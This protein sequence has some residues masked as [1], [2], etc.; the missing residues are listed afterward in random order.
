MTDRPS[1]VITGGGTGIGFAVA[2]RLLSA[3]LDV[4]IAGRRESVLESAATE[5]G[6][7][8]GAGRVR[9]C[10]VDIGSDTGPVQ[11]ISAHVE[12]YG[13][14]AALVTAAAIYDAVGFTEITREAWDRTMRI[15]V[16]GA[17][18]C[19]VEA[20]RHMVANGHGRIVFIGSTN[21]YHA[22]RGSTLYS[23][24]KTALMSVAKSIAVDLAGT[25]VVGN[26]VAPGWT[27]TPMAAKDIDRLGSDGMKH[28][29]PQGRAAR[30]EEIAE[31][32]WYLTAD[33]PDHLSGQTIFVDGGQTA[34]AP[35]P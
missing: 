8:A 24:S 1:A 7:E 20:T 12:S 16:R 5:L 14:I 30:P 33:A 11:L 22:E 25:G 10:A 17:V 34:M 2:R 32:V 23:A 6:R 9:T 15:N 21:A 31:V 3:G 26:V 28:V 18:L 19:A 29:N 13:G 27:Y 4:T 35:L